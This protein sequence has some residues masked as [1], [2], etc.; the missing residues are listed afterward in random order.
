MATNTV[1]TT[2]IITGTSTTTFTLTRIWKQQI[3][4]DSLSYN[5]AVCYIGRVAFHSFRCLRTDFARHEHCWWQ[6]SIPTSTTSFL[7]VLLNRPQLKRKIERFLWRHPSTALW[8]NENAIAQ[9]GQL[10]EIPIGPYRRS[11]VIMCTLNIDTVVDST[12]Y[13]EIILKSK[14]A[15]LFE[16]IRYKQINNIQLPQNVK[17]RN[18]VVTSPELMFV[19]DHMQSKGLIVWKTTLFI[20]GVVMVT[21]PGGRVPSVNCE[22]LLYYFDRTSYQ[23]KTV[24]DHWLNSISLSSFSKLPVCDSNTHCSS[25]QSSSSS[26]ERRSSSRSQNLARLPLR[27]WYTAWDPHN[28]PADTT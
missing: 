3:R 19:F 24:A 25:L 28:R 22:L 17:S 8:R 21:L 14:R 11:Y 26:A 1:P 5:S 16:D 10:V 9:T 15:A 20:K 12:P 18:R 4:K 27:Q 2:H 23:N 6:L 7:T 13:V